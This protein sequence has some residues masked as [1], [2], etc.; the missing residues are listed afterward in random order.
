MPTKTCKDCGKIK[1][2]DLFRKNTS[3]CKECINAKSKSTKDAADKPEVKEVKKED[4]KEEK[5]K[6]PKTAEE[7]YIKELDKSKVLF[8]DFIKNSS[9]ESVK[10]NKNAVSNN[11]LTLI[12]KL[13]KLKDAA[14]AI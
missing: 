14:D 6:V 10:K 4:K 5:K 12:G 13:S 2:E 11:I 3:V 7:K 8:E 9:L 1:E